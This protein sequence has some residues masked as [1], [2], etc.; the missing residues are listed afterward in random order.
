MIS[1]DCKCFQVMTQEKETN[2][3]MENRTPSEVA[4]SEIIVVEQAGEVR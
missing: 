2:L 3:E 4:S 1:S